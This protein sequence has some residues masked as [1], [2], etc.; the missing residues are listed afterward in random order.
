MIPDV[1]YRFTIRP[2]AE[3]EG[4]GYLIAFPNL[5]GCMSDGGDARSS[6][7]QWHPRHGGWIAA[8]RAHGH[9]IPAP[10]HSTAA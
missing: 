10:T 3:H 6:D 5:P 8:M 2:L 1:P 9:P 7:R 4:A